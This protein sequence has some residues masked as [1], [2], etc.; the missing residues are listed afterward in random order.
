MF[1]YHS[2]AITDEEVT[3][4]LDTRACL[5]RWTQQLIAFWH[6]HLEGQPWA[7]DDFD[8]D[9]LEE[10]VLKLGNKIKELADTP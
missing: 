10:I 3:R 8:L 1:S 9:L 2:V 7:G 5:L 6:T 4:L